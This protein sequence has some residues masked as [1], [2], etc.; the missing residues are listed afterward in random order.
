MKRFAIAAA[1]ATVLG[2]GFAGKAEAQYYY[3]NTAITP[4]GGLVTTN[5]AYTPFGVQAR[6]VYVAPNGAVKRQYVTGDLFGNTYMS[7]GFN[8]NTGLFYNRGFY[9][10]SPIV[11]PYSG[12]Y[13]YSFYRRW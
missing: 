13:G 7:N 6:N 1:L 10:P 9:N 2:L 4:N 3:R 11:Y 12:G 8:P 5:Q